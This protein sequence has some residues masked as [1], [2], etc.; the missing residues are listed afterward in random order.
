TLLQERATI[1]GAIAT[2]AR[3]AR[4][5]RTRS[6]HAC[7]P[8]QSAGQARKT[9][10]ARDRP[11]CEGPA[12]EGP[13]CEGPACEGPACEG[14]AC[15]GCADWRCGGPWASSPPLGPGAGDDDA[16]ALLPRSM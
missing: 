1:A 3:E 6:P 9:E 11:A 10:P 12:C 4:R 8:P 15:D 5:C 13:A 14:P 7:L 2:A 16:L